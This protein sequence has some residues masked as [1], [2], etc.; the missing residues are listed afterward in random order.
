MIAL[1]LL[2]ACGGEKP[3]DPKAP[4]APG[5]LSRQTYVTGAEATAKISEFHRRAKTLTN[6]WAASYGA[7]D[8]FWVFAAQYPTAEEALGAV[9]DMSRAAPMTGRY[10]APINK[11]IAYQAGLQMRDSETN[12]NIFFFAKQRWVVAAWVTIPSDMEIAVASIEW[13]PAGN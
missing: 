13:V 11:N 6:T 5:G 12:A 9:N 2:A 3:V 8:R 7:G 4:E 1:L 10:S